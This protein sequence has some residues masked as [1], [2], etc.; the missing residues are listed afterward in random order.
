MKNKS[1]AVRQFDDTVE[2]L[3]IDLINGEREIIP[4]NGIEKNRVGFGFFEVEKKKM[5]LELEKIN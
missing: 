5:R 2:L 1:V 4:F 3:K